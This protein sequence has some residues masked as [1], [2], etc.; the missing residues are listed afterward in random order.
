MMFREFAPR[1]VGEGGRTMRGDIVKT[2]IRTQLVGEPCQG[3]PVHVTMIL[4]SGFVG[5]C[6]HPLAPGSAVALNV[7]G[8]GL[9]AAEV[10]WAF[11]ERA[12]FKFA[13]PLTLDQLKRLA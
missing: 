1:P 13:R 5:E 4:A 12:G 6:A 7:A 11:G 10:Q 9:V 3:A 2:S 8:L